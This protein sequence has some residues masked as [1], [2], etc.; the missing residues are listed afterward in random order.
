MGQLDTDPVRAEPVHQIGQRRR[1]G[2][3]STGG[4]R[5]ADVA[6]A[7]TGQDVPVPARRVGERIEVEAQ[8]AFL[9][10]GKMRRGQLPRQSAIAFRP[11]RQHQQMR[12]GR[13]RIVGPGAGSQRQ[14]G[15]EHR[16]HVQLH[17]RFGEPHRPVEAVVIGQR[18]GPQAEPHRLLDQFF[19]RA[20]SIEEAVRRMRVQLG[21]R[22]RR[23]HRP[24]VVRWLVCHSLA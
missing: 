7:T 22:D 6:F 2:L 17:R 11:A 16:T 21:I 12:A 19:R 3:R 9:T 23:T 20:G 18:D 15:A 5:G 14:L 10:A 13:I 4:Q 1:G 8:L 24:A